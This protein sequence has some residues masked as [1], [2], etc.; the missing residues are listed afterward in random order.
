VTRAHHLPTDRVAVVRNTLAVPRAN[1]AQPVPGKP[2]VFAAARWWDAAKNFAALDAAAAL[3]PWRVVAAGPVVGPDGS[4]V[5]A[6]HVHALGPC[7][8]ST[9]AALMARAGIFASPSLY[10]PFGLATLEAAQA[11][12]AL[13]LSDIPTYRELWD[14]A[15]AFA[16]PRD[17]R[18]F[19]LE[20]ARVAAHEPLRGELAARATRRARRFDIGR[21][22]EAMLAV[23]AGAIARRGR[24]LAAE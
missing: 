4:R 2:F 12:C 10:E 6:R 5:E 13:V 24:A 7:D 14:G 1:S 11:G 15:A 19:G 23:Y 16:S 22:A 9:V 20:L 3:A 17:P 18:A 21:Q 8:R